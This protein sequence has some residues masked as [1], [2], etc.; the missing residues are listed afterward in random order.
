M[1]KPEASRPVPFIMHTVILIIMVQGII[2]SLFFG[3]VWL[4]SIGYVNFLTEKM[5]AI[6][7]YPDATYYVI[8]N[9]LLHMGL[10]GSA[11]ML[12][13]LRVMGLYLFISLLIMLIGL[14]S[15]FLS[16][17]PLFVISAT[18][19]VLIPLLFYSKKLR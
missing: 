19:L 3:V 8:G 11:L 5:N 18:L 9:A 2:G 14:N 4:Q 15:F 7:A 13:R 1:K 16:E 17:M 10:I 6:G 12:Y